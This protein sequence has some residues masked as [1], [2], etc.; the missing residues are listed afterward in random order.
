MLLFNR[1]NE[2]VE[3]EDDDDGTAAA[4]GAVDVLLVFGGIVEM[5]VEGGRDGP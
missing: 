1:V 5:C 3:W 4:V 2:G